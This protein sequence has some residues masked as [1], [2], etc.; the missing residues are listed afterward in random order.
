[1]AQS[2]A[3]RFTGIIPPVL[4]PFTTDGAIDER[5]YDAVIDWLC[6]RPIG[7][8]FV[9]G[10][11]GE[12]RYMSWTERERIIHLAMEAT[13][14]R[15][16]VVPHIGGVNQI[17]EIAKLGK[18]AAK[19]GAFAVALISPDDIPEGPEPLYQHVKAVSDA[20]ELPLAIYDIH[21]SGP[22]SVTPALMKRMLDD[23]IDIVAIK[24]R[25]LRGDD[26]LA[27]VEAAGDRVSILAGAETVFL[28]T[29]A[30]GGVG[31]IG[32]GCNIYPGL[33]KQMQDDYAAG[34]NQEALEA[35]RRVNHLLDES[36]R[37]NWP[38]A[39]KVI[40]AAWGLPVQP[41]VRAPCERRDP[42]AIKKVQEIFAPLQYLAG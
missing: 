25:S 21:G 5:G 26:M 19:L 33:L 31:V 11:L 1:M 34:R 37:V 9:M 36:E 40:W 2:Q 6:K 42:A 29:L 8:L 23:G 3:H 32:G 35:Q 39:G 24:Y 18:T 27:M 15:L 14:G 41:V 28:P 30:V 10:G 7:G 12:W 17:A 22:R 16:P 13:D 38:L 4:T 20:V